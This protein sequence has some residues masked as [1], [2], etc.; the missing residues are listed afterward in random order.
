MRN[1]IAMLVMVS[2]AAFCARAAAPEKTY[3]LDDEG[4][5]RNWLVADPVQLDDKASNHDEE[6]QKAF[7]DK[8]YVKKMEANP[9]PGDKLKADGK[10]L[11]WKAEEAEDFN[12]NLIKVGEKR[13]ASTDNTLWLGVAYVWTDD[14]VKGAKLSIGS[15]DSS[16]WWVNGKEVIRVYAG[17]A[18]EKDQDSS[19]E[20]T[21][22]K[23]MN[24]VRFAVINGNGEAGA[25]AHFKNAGGDAIKNL[26]V[27]VEPG[28]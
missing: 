21:L 14:E 17:R 22:K 5:I 23:G 8:D 1:V 4:F 12:L 25:C 6:N 9:K 24:V 16:V 20:L 10:D 26:K 7:F 3:K 15:D 2:V 28:N 18:S 19:S 13:S 27:S 11:N